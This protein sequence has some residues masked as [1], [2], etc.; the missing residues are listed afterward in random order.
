VENCST[1]D[2]SP[3]GDFVVL[4]VDVVVVDV[5][6]GFV[7]VVDVVEVVVVVDVD[8]VDVVV[9][10]VGGSSASQTLLSFASR[11]H[12]LPIIAFGA[13]Q[14]LSSRQPQKRMADTK[15]RNKNFLL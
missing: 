7:V 5:V 12:L 8:V 3:H 4:V 15:A 11:Q 13:L 1:Q 9:V 6:V 10:V 2:L 14:D